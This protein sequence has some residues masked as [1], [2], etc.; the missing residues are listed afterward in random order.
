MGEPFVDFFL[1]GIGTVILGF[2]ADRFVVSTVRLANRLQV[3]TVVAGALIVGFG[4]SA[5]EMMVSILA[6]VGENSEGLKIAVGNIVGSNAANLSLVLAIPILFCGGFRVQRDSYRQAVLSSIA[7][8]VFA[9]LVFVNWSEIFKGIILLG[10]FL[11]F[12][13]FATRLGEGTEEQSAIVEGGTPL[14]DWMWTVLGLGGTVGSAYI[15]VNA[16]IGIGEYYGWTGGFVGFTLVAVGTSLPEL[17]TA[18]VAAVRGQWGLI[19]GNVLGS[20]VF[21]SLG[22]GAAVFLTYSTQQSPSVRAPIDDWVL[23]GMIV[24]SFFVLATLF[25]S[26]GQISR[27]VSVP[28]MILYFLLIWRMREIA[29]I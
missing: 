3:S 11:M 24:V 25:L 21:N 20:N 5:P 8:L 18:V 29:I 15:V 16:S 26:K 27:W 9:I 19:V 23:L 1:L 2:S 13:Y 10:A 12:L 14:R 7:V 4:T 17:V 28:L 22:V 6:V